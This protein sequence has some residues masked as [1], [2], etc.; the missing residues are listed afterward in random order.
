MSHRRYDQRNGQR[1]Y[2][3]TKDGVERDKMVAAGSLPARVS[4]AGDG[5]KTAYI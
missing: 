5:P 4:R 3:S 1:G 2:F